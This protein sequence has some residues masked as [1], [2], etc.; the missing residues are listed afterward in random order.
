MPGHALGKSPPWATP[1]AH[2]WTIAS[3]LPAEALA[4]VF[5]TAG[6]LPN[7]KP[8]WNMAPTKDA[9]IVLFDLDAGE[10]PGKGGS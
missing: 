2:V 10:G 6:Q 3:F 4:R 1:W 8:T 9:P 5:G 7:L